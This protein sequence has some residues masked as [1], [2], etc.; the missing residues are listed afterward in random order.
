M[1]KPLKV[2]QTG[3]NLMSN[4]FQPYEEIQTEAVLRYEQ[5]SKYVCDSILKTSKANSHATVRRRC[6]IEVQ[7]ESGRWPKSRM[8]F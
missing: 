2:I 7:V 8:M 6:Q 3:A 5:K 1:P 4:R